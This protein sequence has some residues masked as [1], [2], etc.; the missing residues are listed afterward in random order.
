MIPSRMYN[1]ICHTQL[2]SNHVRRDRLACLLQLPNVSRVHPLPA[3]ESRTFF[4]TTDHDQGGGLNISRNLS[5][6]TA[7]TEYISGPDTNRKPVINSNNSIDCN[8][9]KTFNKQGSH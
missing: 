9:S 6:P 8:R 1:T 3:V 5:R 4:C 2:G 7:G